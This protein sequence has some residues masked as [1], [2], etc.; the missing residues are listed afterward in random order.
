[1]NLIK[2][3]ETH[4]TV[5]YKQC[6]ECLHAL[7]KAEKAE[8]KANDQRN[9]KLLQQKVKQSAPRKT[10]SKNPKD[11]SNTFLCSDGTRVTQAEINEKRSNAYAKYD[12]LYEISHCE[13]CGGKPNGHAHIVPQAMC[14]T[15]GWT[16]LIWNMQ[17]FFVSC[18]DCNRAIENPKGRDWKHLKNLAHCLFIINTYAPEHFAKFEL[19]A[20]DQSKPTI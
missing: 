14:K 2:T 3:C 15:L 4:H 9:K 18:N 6:S 16:E 8:K 1:M 17:N 20:I 19:S 5:Y 12:N 11:W 10:I 7:A 13:G